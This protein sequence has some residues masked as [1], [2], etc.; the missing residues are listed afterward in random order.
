MKV[1]E[2]R[3]Q[4][5]DYEIYYVDANDDGH[6]IAAVY[7]RRDAFYIANLL[8]CEYNGGHEVFRDGKRIHPEKGK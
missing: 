5:L 7:D 8:N 4:G 3:L 6:L 1:H 2:E